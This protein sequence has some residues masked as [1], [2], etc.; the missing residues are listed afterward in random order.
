MTPLAAVSV[1]KFT[2]SAKYRKYTARKD[3]SVNVPTEHNTVPNHRFMTSRCVSV[4]AQI[5]AYLV[6]PLRFITQLLAAAYVPINCI[7]LK[8]NISTP[9]H[10]SANAP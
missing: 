1:Q 6:N 4:F 2:L 5:V 8:N 3:V 7:A 10:V 9:R